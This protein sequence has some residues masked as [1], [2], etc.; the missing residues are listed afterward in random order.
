M[1]IVILSG[2]SGSG[3]SVA[4]R[5]L[6]DQGFYCVDNIPVSLLPTLLERTFSSYP[7]LAFSIDARNQL[8]E[9]AL[10]ETVY[11]TLRAR[12]GR[13]IVIYT[14]ADDATLLKRFSETRRRHPLTHGGLSL[15]EA[16]A[17][18]RTLLT[19]IALRADLLI[20]TTTLSSHKLR[21]IVLD[22]VSGR[23]SAGLDLL[24]ESFGFKN[25]VPT[26]ADYVF[27]ARCLPNPYWDPV[28][29]PYSGQDA[30]VI[31]F[32]EQQPR[33]AEFAWQV[34][35]FL[36]TWIPR[37]EQENRSYL[38]VAIG[39]T[40]GQHRSVYIAEQLAAHFRNTR[41]RTQVRHRDMR[42]HVP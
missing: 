33:V 12:Y 39:C 10:F 31:D 1:S 15:N 36:D 7:E 21:E 27:D 6:E 40:G 18:E 38:T 23:D 22:R 30:P 14:D 9:L 29:R 42:S 32:F 13:P 34:R 26:D 24:F 25:G 16:I 5:A 4:L 3:K 8:G 28:L 11:D 35:I 37:F 19:P 20:D 2:R 17:Q 41:P